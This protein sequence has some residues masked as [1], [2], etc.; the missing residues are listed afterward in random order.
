MEF[1]PAQLRALN[2][3]VSEGTFEAAARVL[4]VTP[5]AVSQRLKALEIAAGRVLLVRTKPIRV[6]A[7]GVVVL[8]LARQ[9]ELLA[10]DTA[11][12]LGSAETGSH[13]ALPLA[14]NADSLATW[15]LPALAPLAGAI[16][17]DIHRE[18]EDHTSELLREG[19]V[20]AAITTQARPVPGCR[21][22]RLGVMRYRPMAAPGFVDQWFPTGVTPAA[23]ARAPVMVFDRNDDIQHR[24]L[25]RRTGKSVEPPVHHVPASS[26]FRAAIELGFGWGMLPDLQSR[27]AERSG[28]VVD[29]D[30]D[31]A[32]NVVLHWQQW[33]LRSS[34]LDQVAE[35]VVAAAKAQLR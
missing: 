7:S 8:R 9:I 2:A 28:S 34:R 6:T 21:S 16:E 23:L 13:A 4:R 1:D 22:V 32:I 26:D 14:V 30:P 35:A 17:F 24:Y 5:S 25:R 12:E 3:A 15:V 11:L 31:G 29:L 20:M 33:R 27:P 19:S 10:A 18:D